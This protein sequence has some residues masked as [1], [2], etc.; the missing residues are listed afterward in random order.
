MER[1]SE[2]TGATSSGGLGRGVFDVLAH[3]AV[4]EALAR[5]HDVPEI[6]TEATEATTPPVAAASLMVSSAALQRRR[7]GSSSRY[8]LS[9]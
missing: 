4:R 8:Q 2:V 5:A 6:D 7:S 3:L 1:N 9:A